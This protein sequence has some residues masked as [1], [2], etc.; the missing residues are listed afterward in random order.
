MGESD[1][2]GSV[3]D[4]IDR[5]GKTASLQTCAV[6]PNKHRRMPGI[7]PADKDAK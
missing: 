5:I 3:E 1:I 4:G 2:G 7:D 6:I